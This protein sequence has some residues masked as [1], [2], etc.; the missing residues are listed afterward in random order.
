M[1][2]FSC[3]NQKKI[4]NAKTN[5]IVC[6]FIKIHIHLYVWIYAI[7]IEMNVIG[8]IDWVTVVVAQTLRLKL[9]CYRS[10]F[11]TVAVTV[12]SQLFLYNVAVAF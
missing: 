5:I 4:K 7:F 8:Q 1:C 11:I 3:K 9:Y 2:I 10:V 12:T 6:F